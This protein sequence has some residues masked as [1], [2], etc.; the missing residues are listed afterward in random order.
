MIVKILRD[1][2]QARANVYRLLA[3]ALI[4]EPQ[5]DYLQALRTP[6][7]MESLNEMGVKF[8]DD[9]TA[10]ELEQL[11]ES[12]AN[13]FAV[14]FVTPGGCPAVESVRLTGRFQ[15]EPLFAVREFYRRSGFQLAETRFAVFEDQL[16]VELMFVAELLEKSA[17]LLT[18]CDNEGYARLEK[19]IKRFWVQHPGKWVRG[20]ATLLGRATQHS[21]YREMARLLGSFAA[22]EIDLLGIKVDDVDGG[23]AV[24]AKAEIPLEFNPDEPVCGGCEHGRKSD[25]LLA[26]A[27]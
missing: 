8:D 4:E 19:E 22:W 10:P 1:E 21:F 12:L 24:V 17:A 16:G 27:G 3:G 26:Q 2:C 25:D 7:A 15:Q 23:K 11:Q 20:Y 13:E 6:E 5:V 18:V 14:L 9:F